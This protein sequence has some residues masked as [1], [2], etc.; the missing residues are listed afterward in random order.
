MAEY[1]LKTGK[2]GKKV[3]GAY[4]KV[5]K[6]FVDTFLHEDGSMKTGD[7]AEKVGSV[8]RTIEDSVIG[9]YKKAEDAFV[10]AFVNAFL[11]KADE[12]KM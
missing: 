9:A 7:M 4:E 11:V 1:K 12:D 10:N 5:E 2:F 3:T 8:Y 6:K